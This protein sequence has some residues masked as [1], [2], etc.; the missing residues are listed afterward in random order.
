MSPPIYFP[1][2]SVSIFKVSD[3]FLLPS[4]S[5]SFGL[6]ALEAMSFGCPVITSSNGSL[7]EV[8]KDAVLYVDPENIIEIGEKI[9]Y[10]IKNRSNQL[11][12]INK[13]YEVCKLY[14]LDSTIDHTYNYI[15]DIIK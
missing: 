2:I 12:L 11:H 6:V 1:I 10:L 5:E 3:L 4:E 7:S 14:N 13:G 8:C 15:K 9:K